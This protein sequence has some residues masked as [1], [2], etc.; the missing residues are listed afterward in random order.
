MIASGRS[1]GFPRK[2]S[3]SVRFCL[4]SR[5][6]ALDWSRRASR[7]PRCDVVLMLTGRHNH[8]C[9]S[10]CM[11]DMENIKT[12]GTP[13]RWENHLTVVEKKH[14]AACRVEGC[15]EELRRKE[16]N[17]RPPGYEP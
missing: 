1:A 6:E 17:L 12:A 9:H 16:S 7:I 2:S 3:N 10:A 5:K 4:H 14:P 8:S 11:C 13:V 15:G